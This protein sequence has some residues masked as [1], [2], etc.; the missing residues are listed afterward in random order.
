MAFY[1]IAA[2][3][4]NMAFIVG[5]AGYRISMFFLDEEANAEM[6]LQYTGI[7]VPGIRVAEMVVAVHALEV[8]VSI[9][10]LAQTFWDW[11]H[12]FGAWRRTSAV[13]L[14]LAGAFNFARER[15]SSSMRSA[16][17]LV[18]SVCSAG[19]RGSKVSGGPESKPVE[20]VERYASETRLHSRESHNNRQHVSQL[21]YAG[22]TSSIYRASGV[23]KA[24]K[25]SRFRESRASGA[26]AMGGTFSMTSNASMVSL[27]SRPIIQ[28]MYL[29]M[30]R[31]FWRDLPRMQTFSMLRLLAYVHPDLIIKNRRKFTM[32]ESV[33]R[34]ILE[35][36]LRK[37]EDEVTDEELQQEVIQLLLRYVHAD[38]SSV[39]ERHRLAIAYMHLSN[40]ELVRA[41][42]LQKD[43]LEAA[44]P[45]PSDLEAGR[46]QEVGSCQTNIAALN[47][48]WRLKLVLF[49]EHVGFVLLCFFC[50]SVGVASFVSKLCFA[51]VWLQAQEK[52]ARA[53][54]ATALIVFAFLNQVMGIVSAKELLMER[55]EAFVF[56]GSDA[57]LSAEERFIAKAYLANLTHKI[58]TCTF[59]TTWQKWTVMLLLG[60][61]EFQ[62]LIVEEDTK[63][64]SAIIL[65][66]KQF[67]RENGYHRHGSLVRWFRTE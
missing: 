14:R 42:L 18:K 13:E 47:I 41:L 64:K 52:D 62:G 29:H 25:A 6:H 10:I 8:L 30:S 2:G 5:F 38:V 7:E 57:R 67:M 63:A 50:G 33:A 21:S 53:H 12:C 35:S 9:T 17:T 34:A 51:S 66:V 32:R 61:D 43:E 16:S 65:G 36:F 27:L 56:G 19:I 40:Y 49:L 45:V 60:D 44:L 3:I 59:L 4:L 28:P 15:T 54:A 31:L 20:A 39:E 23:S 11:Y 58:W 26:T 46:S 24:S 22:P 1:R 37:P 48:K 55:L